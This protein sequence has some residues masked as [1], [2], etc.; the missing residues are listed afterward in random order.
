MY[1]IPLKIVGFLAQLIPLS[2]ESEFHNRKILLK[3]KYHV[4]YQVFFTLNHQVNIPDDN[5]HW[6]FGE[7][8]ISDENKTT[9]VFFCSL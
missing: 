5:S 6:S 8:T 7:Y 2:S 1:M 4:K 9:E 3:K